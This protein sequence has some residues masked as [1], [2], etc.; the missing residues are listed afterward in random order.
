M[1]KPTGF[2]EFE[3]HDRAY[4]PV[5]E[6]LKSYKEFVIPLA[7]AELKQQAGRCMDCGIPFC[8]NGCPINNQ[9]P[10]WNDLVYTGAWK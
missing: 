9:I 3:R 10:D 1:G 5:E 2:L 8:H 4:A 6:R 7:D